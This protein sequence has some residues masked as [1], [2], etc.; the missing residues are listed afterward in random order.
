MDLS[1]L[2][3]SFHVGV[4]KMSVTRV[5][6]VTTFSLPLFA[7]FL[8][9]T[10]THPA[11]RC[12]SG[13]SA[14]WHT[15]FSGGLVEFLP[16]ILRSTTTSSP[17]LSISLSMR[18]PAPFLFFVGGTQSARWPLLKDGLRALNLDFFFGRSPSSSPSFSSA[19]SS[20]R[21]P[22]TS[23][24]SSNDKSTFS[25]DLS[26]MQKEQKLGKHRFIWPHTLH[27]HCSS[28]SN[29][30]NMDMVTVATRETRRW[31]DISH[32]GGSRSFLDSRCMSVRGMDGRIDGRRRVQD[33]QDA[34]CPMTSHDR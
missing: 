3:R 17:W 32:V 25:D 19:S 14:I 7:T 27:L 23:I 10:A 9:C 34:S 21:E 20:S 18:T 30:L 4:S 29:T 22:S 6:K 2:Y 26:E 24:F 16:P 28:S 13:V 31:A 8:N 15:I 11:A 5:Q 33:V 1:A 12:C